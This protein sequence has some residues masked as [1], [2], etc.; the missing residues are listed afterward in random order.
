MIT[1]E[2]LFTGSEDSAQKALFAWIA[3]NRQKYPALEWLYHVPNG[4]RRDVRE[5][6]K[7]KAIGVKPGVLDLNLDLPRYA[8]A[9]GPEV[10]Y[11]GLRIEL[12]VASGKVSDDQKKWLAHLT[13]AGYFAKVVWSWEE[14][15]DLLIWYIN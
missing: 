13:E 9:D 11:H 10:A 6:A 12:K 14:A 2:S 15:R 4:G 8:N 3:L 5:A 1:P 7:L